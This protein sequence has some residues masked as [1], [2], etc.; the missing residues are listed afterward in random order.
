MIS[1]GYQILDLYGEGIP[2]VL[3]NNGR[4]TLYWEP[5]AKGEGSKAVKYN[6]PQQP[7]SLPL[8]YGKTNNQQLIDLTGNGQLDLVLSTPKVSGYYEVKSDRSWQSFQTFPAFTNRHL[9]NKN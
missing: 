1:S 9:Q 7:Q 4:T 3:Y 5:A 8:P 2:G 6:P